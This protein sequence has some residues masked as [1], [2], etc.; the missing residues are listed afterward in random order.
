MRR[1]EFITLVGG[2]A[3]AWPQAVLAQQT[4]KLPRIG[5]LWHAGSAEEEGPYFRG[6]I[7]GLRGLGYI[8]GSNIIL[9]HRFPN[10]TPDRFR[11]MAAEL[12]SSKVDVLI[13]VGSQTAPYVKNATTT[14][15]IIFV[16]SPDPVG[17]KLVASLARPGGNATGLTNFAADLIGKRLQFLELAIPGL[18]R[19]A[20]LVNPSTQVARL[21]TDVTQAAAAKLDLINHTFE[22]QTRDGLEPA[23][24]KMAE[25]GIQ[26]VT[27]NSEGVAYQHREFIAKLAV[28]RRLPLSVWSRETLEAG[29]LMS[30]GPDQVAMCRR[31]AVFVDKIL[32][33]AN[34]AELPVEEPTKVE[35]LINLKTAGALGISI[36]YTLLA[37]ADEVIE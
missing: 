10:E 18:S 35:F 27:I 28:A 9:E 31:A 6:L 14:I 13:G 15:P 3:A 21:Y 34:P 2:A 12:V 37:N 26:A 4:G 25:S 7:E 1:R 36:P 33:G 32:K 23:F 20:L 17:T 24:D 8:D 22:A 30:Y 5:V 29:A 11:S 19:V 16:F